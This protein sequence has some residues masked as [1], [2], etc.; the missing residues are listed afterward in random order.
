MIVAR[1]VLGINA[2]S[3][4]FS[5]LFDCPSKPAAWTCPYFRN[6]CSKD[7]SPRGDRTDEGLETSRATRPLGL[8]RNPSPLLHWLAWMGW[9]SWFDRP[10]APGLSRRAW[11]TC[12][13]STS[14]EGNGAPLLVLG[15]GIPWILPF[16]C[17]LTSRLLLPACL[18]R[19]HCHASIYQVFYFIIIVDGG[20]HV[21]VATCKGPLS[22]DRALEVDG[23]AAVVSALQPYLVLP[24]PVRNGNLQAA[25]SLP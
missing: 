22:P 1:V 17:H 4:A 16:W 21:R 24:I 25:H 7:P 12:I 2:K 14:L 8:G 9:N 11:P 6:A 23:A 19:L 3:A 18:S 20:G 5:T 15:P 13:L 10:M